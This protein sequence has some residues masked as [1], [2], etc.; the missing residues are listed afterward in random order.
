MRAV[1][2]LRLNEREALALSGALAFYGFPSCA[3]FLHGAAL[4]LIAHHQ[5]LAQ[6]STPLVFRSFPEA[7][8][9]ADLMSQRLL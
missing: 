9:S 4:A 2:T 8:K 7:F 1:G 3:A 6:L 5:A